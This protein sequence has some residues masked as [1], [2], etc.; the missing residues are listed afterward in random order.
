MSV[1]KFNR[2]TAALGTLSEVCEKCL[3]AD[4]LGRQLLHNARNYG[5]LKHRPTPEMKAMFVPRRGSGRRRE[6]RWGPPE[7]ALA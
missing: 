1:E 6:E 3:E 4:S 5:D 7:I 2:E